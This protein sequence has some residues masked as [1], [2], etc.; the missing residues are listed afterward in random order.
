[1]FRTTATV[2]PSLFIALTFGW[3]YLV[4][5]LHRKGLGWGDDPAAAVIKKQ[6]EMAVRMFGLDQVLEDC[7]KRL[8]EA[9]PREQWEPG[10]RQS[11]LELARLIATGIVSRHY[12][13]AAA[14]PAEVAL[15]SQHAKTNGCVHATFTVDQALPDDLAIGAFR[16]GARYDAVL[17]VSNANGSVQPDRT[18][19][20]RGMAIKLLSTDGSTVQ[21]FVLVNFPVFFVDDVAEYKRFMEIIHGRRSRLVTALRVFGFFVPWRLRKG[22]IFLRLRT[23]IADPFDATYHSMSPFAHGSRVVRYI[24]AP[25]QPSGDGASDRERRDFLRDRLQRRLSGPDSVA[26]DFSI[27][28]RDRPT[29]QDVEQASR[30]WR[31]PADR[32]VPVAR[33]EVP[34]QV[35]TTADKF[36]TCEGMTFSP[37]HCLPEHRP[38]GGIN[39]SRLL[40][41]LVSSRVRRRLNMVDNR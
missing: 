39:R 33:I 18:G 30:A 7:L 10:E 37:W 41:Y 24:V 12:E 32:I 40:A 31:R 19:D 34:P 27:Q 5:L 29:P 25:A 9:D 8:P 17:R 6:A 11:Y 23:R 38:L 36:C 15:R 3:R 21:D 2:G 13:Q 26:L 20:G 4:N 16:R 35:F 14:L 1:V 22:I 28:I